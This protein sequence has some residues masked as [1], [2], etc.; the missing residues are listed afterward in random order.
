MKYWFQYCDLHR[1]LVKC[2]KPAEKCTENLRTRSTVDMLASDK[3]FCF[4]LSFIFPALI[5]NPNN[6]EIIRLTRLVVSRMFLLP[7]SVS[8]MSF[9]SY[10]SFF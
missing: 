7:Y 1:A 9:S 5:G 6:F 2:Q 3:I 4:F 8:F 10:W